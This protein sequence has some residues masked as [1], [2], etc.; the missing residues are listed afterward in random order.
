MALIDNATSLG[1]MLGA[2]IG[3]ML[4]LSLHGN[5]NGFRVTHM[6]VGLFALLWI[7]WVSILKKVGLTPGQDALEVTGSLFGKDYLA[8]THHKKVA[9]GRSTSI[10]GEF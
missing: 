8:M 5:G 7:P 2:W 6:V 4:Y 9:R 10:G 1:H 3:P